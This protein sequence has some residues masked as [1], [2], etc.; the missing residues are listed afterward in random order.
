[1][2]RRHSNLYA[3]YRVDHEASR[4]HSWL[5]TLERRGRIYH[6]HCSDRVHGGKRNALAAAKTY[7]GRSRLGAA[8]PDPAGRVR[9]QEKNNRSGISDLTR[10]D[11]V[12][13]KPRSDLSS[14]L[15]GR[16]MTH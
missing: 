10:V 13:R 11:M 14:H 16:P 4:T 6:R 12:E 15:L 9:H 3:I 5:V 2:P 8:I 1:M 7:C